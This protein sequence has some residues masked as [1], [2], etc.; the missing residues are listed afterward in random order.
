MDLPLLDFLIKTNTLQYFYFCYLK[1]TLKH[2][3]FSIV[4]SSFGLAKCVSYLDLIVLLLFQT[5]TSTLM[6][7]HIF[8]YI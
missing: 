3:L 6:Q 8:I 5:Q 1:A 7:K 4:F 2:F